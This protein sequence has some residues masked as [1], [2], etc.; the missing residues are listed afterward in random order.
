MRECRGDC[1]CALLPCYEV[2][3]AF[4]PTSGEVRAV[5]TAAL[6]ERESLRR[7]FSA[8]CAAPEPSERRAMTGFYKCTLFSERKPA[9]RRNFRRA[10]KGFFGIHFFR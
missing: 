1:L 8:S 6:A 9:F 5:R 10:M 4:S 7:V 3:A 2:C